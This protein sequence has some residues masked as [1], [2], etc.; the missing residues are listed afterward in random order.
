MNVG[1]K[2]GCVPG[3]EQEALLFKKAKFNYFC[4]VAKLI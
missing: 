3:K 2:R 1:S 4:S